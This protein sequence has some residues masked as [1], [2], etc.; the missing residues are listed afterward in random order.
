MSTLI[1]LRHNPLQVAD[2]GKHGTGKEMHGADAADRIVRVPCGTIVR[3]AEGGDILADLTVPKQRVVIA[4]G[5]IGG[6]GNTHFKSQY[7]PK[8]RAW[9][10]R[11]KPG[12]E[13]TIGLEV[14]LIADIGL[15]G[16]PNAGKSTL[17]GRVSSRETENRPIPIH[18]PRAQSRRS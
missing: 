16:Y 8:H 12:E 3:E 17:L 10:K 9:R 2:D 1:D 14:K 13:R 7:L 11:E 15:V 6:K 18:N 4:R 5:G